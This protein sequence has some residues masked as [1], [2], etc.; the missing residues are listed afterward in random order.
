MSSA[1]YGTPSRGTGILNNELYVGR[2]IWNK[3][4]WVRGNADSSVRDPVRNDRKDWIIRTE[5][6]L[7]IIP[8]PLW[9]K[10]RTRLA[11][12]QQVHNGK[13]NGMGA[14]PKWL[15]SGLL[16]CS[17]CGSAYA[18]ADHNCYRCT[19]ATEESSARKTFG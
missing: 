6:R 18:M 1:I 5:E 19:G 2:V 3:Y 8:E 17:D 10:V 7:R 15:F 14:G 12:L 13:V 11:S 16:R 4:R 9:Q